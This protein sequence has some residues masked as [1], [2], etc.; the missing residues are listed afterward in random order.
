MVSVAQLRRR[1][2]DML[3]KAGNDSPRADTDVLISRILGLT[4]TEIL[5]GRTVIDEE[6]ERA[7]ISAAERVKNGEPVQYVVG[8]CEFMSLDFAVNRDTLIPRPDT[9]ILV[10]TA[11]DACGNIPNAEILD[12]GCG[13]GCIG[14]SMAHF[15]PDSHITAIDISEGALKTAAENAERNGVRGRMTFLKCDIMTE[16]P[17]NPYGD[18]FDMIVSNPPYIP[19]RDIE[20]LSPKVRDFEPRRALDGGEDGLKFYRRISESPRLKKGGILAFEVGA[21]QAT[22]VKNIMSAKFENIRIIK[23]LSGIERV[24]FGTYI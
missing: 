15:L 8:A 21:G 1:T 6:S 7:F 13:T 14:I 22:D 23:D 4:K 3:A 12:I 17:E 20:T 2:A 5:M 18:C 24:V 11:L 19:P 16:F 10:E 9:E